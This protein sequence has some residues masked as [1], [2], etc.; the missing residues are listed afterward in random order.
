MGKSWGKW[1]KMV[2]N[3][4]KPLLFVMI[5]APF[6]GSTAPTTSPNLWMISRALSY[7]TWCLYMISI[8]LYMIWIYRFTVYCFTFCINLYIYISTI[9]HML[10]YRLSVSLCFADPSFLQPPEQ[11]PGIQ[12]VVPVVSRCSSCSS[13]CSSCTRSSNLSP[14]GCR[15]LHRKVSC[16][17]WDVM[18]PCGARELDADAWSPPKEIWEGE[19]LGAKSSQESEQNIVL[20]R[21]PIYAYWFEIWDFWEDWSALRL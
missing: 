14:L 10:V 7:Y 20:F 11:Q 15:S 4:G 2:E 18:A 17:H 1:W 19:L 12:P 3:D 5:P 13:P 16:G 21:Q 9:L 8:D 6:K